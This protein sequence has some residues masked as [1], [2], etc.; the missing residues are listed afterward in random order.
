MTDKTMGLPDLPYLRKLLGHAWVHAE[1]V[2]KNPTHS[3]GRWQKSAP[4]N[5]WVPYVEELVKFI[6]TDKRIKFVPKDLRRKLKAEYVSTLA[7]M[8]SA[9]F[10]AQQ[11]FGVTLEP[12]APK[13]GADLRADWEGTPYFVEIRDVGF[14]WEEDRINLISKEIFARL[15]AVPSSYSVAL[16]IGNTYTA[17]SSQLKAAIAVVIDALEVLKED[18]PKNATLYYAHPNGK[19][20]NPGGDL[21]DF[22]GGML[23]RREK[24][25]QDIVDKADII[26][27]FSFLGKQRTG[28]PA[29]LSRKLKLP[30]EPVKTHER[31][32]S[33]LVDKISQLPKDSRGIV[34]L[35]VSEQFMLSEFTIM[36][37][38]YGDLEV[39]FPPVSGPGEPVRE[40]TTKSNERGF[41]GQ[42]SRV[43]AI[44]I[45]KRMMEDG[46]IK[47]SWQVYPTNR[48]NADTIRLNLAELE[49]FGDIGDRKHLS[50][51]SAPNHNDGRVVGK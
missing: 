24:Q 22:R 1:I 23:S 20:L 7:E 21:G 19:L 4:N 44:V 3:L 35:E 31:L 9:V 45:H 17:N 26:A 43:S 32:K 11:G 27:R 15:N 10:L 49:R 34:I 50:A 40:M 28:T 38:L 12:T 51:E 33:I 14:S 42:T 47:G 6:L 8:E 30:P 46:Q 5:P 25:Y 36:S 37:A 18:K 29:T 2:G 39:Q 48:A 16:T 13:K 41:F